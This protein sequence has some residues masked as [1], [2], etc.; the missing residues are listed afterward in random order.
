MLGAILRGIINHKAGKAASLPKFW[1]LV[2]ILN[3]RDHSFK[4]S[5]SLKGAGVKNLPN[6]PKD[7]S[8]KL[9]TVGG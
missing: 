4:T 8:K 9:P 5:A 1:V 3:L 7:S 2:L 6:L